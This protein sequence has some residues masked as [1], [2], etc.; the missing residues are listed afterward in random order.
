MKP[1]RLND[2]GDRE[3]IETGPC[4][5]V[6]RAVAADERVVAVKVLDGM[7]VNRPLLERAA[8]RLEEGEWPPGLMPILEADYRARPAAHVMPCLA[9]EEQGEWRP[10]SLQHRIS[11]FP[12]DDS[13]RVILELVEALAALHERQVAHGNLKPGNVFFGEGGEVLLTDWCL[14]N[15]PGIGHLEFTD[16]CL[17]QPPEQLRSSEGFLDERGY[18]WDV[19]AFGVLAY[20]LLTGGFPRCDQAFG[21]VAPEEGEITREGIVADFAKIA[22]SMESQ[23]VIP[24]PE[25]PSNALETAYREVIG[26]CLALDPLTRP[27]NALEVRRLLREA[28]RFEAEVQARDAVLDQRRHARK[29]ANRARAAA[30]VLGLGALLLGGLWQ[31]SQSQFRGQV[32]GRKRETAE[33]QSRL[34]QAEGERDEAK[35][36]A[37]EANESLKAERSTWLARIEES[38]MLGDHLFGWAMEKGA[39]SLPVLEGRELRLS[40][41]EGY[42]SRFIERTAGEARLAEERARARL[43]LAE[44]SIAKGDSEL[45]AKRLEEAIAGIGHL[46]DGPELSLR[47][48]SNKLKIA[49]LLQQ[50]GNPRAG[51]AFEEARKAL[52]QVPQAGIDADRVT[53]LL[54][55]LDIRESHLLA[56][57][58]EEA[59]ALERLHRATESLNQLSDHRPEAAVLRSELVSCYLSSAT[60]LDGMGELG[61]GRAV[62]ALAADE[63]VKLIKENPADIELR[64]KLAGCYGAIAESAVIAG[65]VGNAQR[66]SK[67]A[68]ELLEG[69]LPQ[70]PDSAVARSRLA[71]QKGLMAGLLRDQGKQEEALGLY[72]EGIRLIE[73]LAVGEDAEAL[74]KYRLAL[75]RWEKGRMMGFMGKREAERELERESAA[76]LEELVDTSYGVVRSEQV[77]RS[78]AYVLGDLGLASQLAGDDEEARESFSRAVT[79]WAE[80]QRERPSSEEYEEALEWNRQR[81]SEL[82]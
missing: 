59:L 71:A 53:Q 45:A 62:R 6:F 26:Q 12:G 79:T 13:W 63:L 37:V 68:T 61:D 10:R 9:D 19:F 67:A 7:A 78:L 48:A 58:G 57:S 32:E 27:A 82:Q 76:A 25:E 73:A 29:S 4:G 69:V 43:Q 60:I 31:L 14:G 28:E 21:Q 1:P 38:R 54:A 72:D 24:W 81:L 5:A 41:L 22:S 11:A 18:R 49:L 2:F 47:L 66:M 75:L 30:L 3:L 80:L 33:L 56:E 51:E 15:M 44:I 36:L 34:D 46:D 23:E 16:A 20:R 77:R 65:D 50:E 42:F 17:Y 40:R 74:A 64:L 35:G 55:I 39:R 70:R 52:E 8:A